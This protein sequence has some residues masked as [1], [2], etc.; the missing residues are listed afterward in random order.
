M[1]ILM[2]SCKWC[3]TVLNEVEIFYDYDKNVFCESCHL[4]NKIQELGITIKE[5]KKWLEETHLK[6]IHEL[7]Q[8][9]EELKKELKEL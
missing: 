7:E 8:E 2:A 5:K 3:G 1:P 9:L 6:Y 4:K